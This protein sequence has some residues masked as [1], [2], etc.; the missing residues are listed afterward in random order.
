MTIGIREMW[1]STNK[2]LT[3]INATLLA[4]L[5]GNVTDPKAIQNARI[6]L[7]ANILLL[8]LLSIG[9]AAAIYKLWT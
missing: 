2:V 6:P 5:T 1:Y 3:I 8:V 9:L 7:Y 4:V